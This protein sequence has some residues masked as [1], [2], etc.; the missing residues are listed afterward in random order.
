MRNELLSGMGEL[1]RRLLEWYILYHL[2]S[3]FK[4]DPLSLVFSVVIL[5]LW[6]LVVVTPCTSAIPCL[7]ALFLLVRP[8]ILVG[9]G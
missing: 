5:Y 1:F 6:H 7:S 9:V 8:Q 2:N 4:G 3:F